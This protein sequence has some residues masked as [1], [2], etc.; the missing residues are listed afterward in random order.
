MGDL[1]TLYPVPVEYE[2]CSGGIKPQFDSSSSPGPST[3]GDDHVEREFSRL[4]S[5][6]KGGFGSGVVPSIGDLHSGHPAAGDRG[7][8]GGLS[9]AGGF[10]S[11]SNIFR[12]SLG[13]I[14]DL[15]RVFA[16]LAK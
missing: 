5:S 11:G 15:R 8:T 1:H 6:P 10:P 12:P 13:H 3:S 7:H 9:A 4:V 14:G 2:F 16:S